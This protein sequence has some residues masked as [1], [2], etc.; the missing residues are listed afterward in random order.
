MHRCLMYFMLNEPFRYDDDTKRFGTASCDGTASYN[1]TVSCNGTV[2][3][4]GIVE[5]G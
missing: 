2:F 4:N 1:R 5:A 3:C